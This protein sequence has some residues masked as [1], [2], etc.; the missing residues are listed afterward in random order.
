[1]SRLVIR[2]GRWI[3]LRKVEVKGRRLRISRWVL[4]GR[5]GCAHGRVC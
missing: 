5:C 4:V 3:L 1:M 2:Y